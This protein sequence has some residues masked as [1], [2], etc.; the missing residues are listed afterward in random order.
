MIDVTS[1]PI[2]LKELRRAHNITQVELAK[3]VGLC[4]M[5]ISKYENG[6]K[7]NYLK[8][9]EMAEIFGVSM[10]YLLGFVDNPQPQ[11]R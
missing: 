11:R 1:F 8:V 3:K 10:D 2:R 6:G 9:L 7:P 4:T 5:T